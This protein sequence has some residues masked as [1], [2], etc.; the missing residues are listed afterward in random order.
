[1]ERDMLG[2][3][4]H[5]AFREIVESRLFLNDMKQ[6]LLP[7]DKGHYMIYTDRRNISKAVGQKRSNISALRELGYDVDIMPLDGAYIEVR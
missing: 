2:G 1:V 6:K 4:Y 3:V 7:M 5:P